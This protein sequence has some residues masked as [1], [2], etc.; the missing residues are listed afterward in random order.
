MPLIPLEKDDSDDAD[1]T[2]C[3]FLCAETK[4]RRFL[5]HKTALKVVRYA[6]KTV[7]QLNNSEE[8][9]EQKEKAIHAPLDVHHSQIELG[10]LLGQGTFSDVF[11]IRNSSVEGIASSRYVV[12]V[13]REKMLHDP[14]LFAAAAAGLLTEATILSL[15]DH[16]NIIGVKAWSHHGACGYL[17]GKNDAFFIV[18]DR[19]D[20]MLSDRITS[21][22][23]EADKIRFSVRHRHMKQDRFF[24]ERIGV[25]RDLATAIS[26][27]HEHRIIH[28]DI[29]PAN[30]GFQ[31]GT[32]KLLDFDVSRILPKETVESQRFNLTGVTGTRR[33]M[34]PECGLRQPYNEKTDVYSF[35]IVLNEIIA[36]E[37]AFTAF[38]KQE[39]EL[40]VFHCGMRPWIPHSCPKHIRSMI[41]R[42]WSEDIARRPSME[43]IH[44]ILEGELTKTPVQPSPS[45]SSRFRFRPFQMIKVFPPTS[46]A[47]PVE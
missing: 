24:R 33:Y 37:K 36:L 29:K 39:H 21:W 26:H 17:S 32:L 3:E 20:V 22:R 25:A 10:D 2:T 35:A 4:K 11:E 1:E 43:E 5:E 14:G 45:P 16:E 44:G 18:L 8:F 42:S 9:Q 19:V 27:L 12:K 41:Q 40:Q 7:K 6:T 23:H 46:V 28:R 13:L 30:I 34:S 15:L 31:E 38:T 47:I